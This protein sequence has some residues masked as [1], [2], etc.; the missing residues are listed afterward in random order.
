MRFP[1]RL[2]IF[3]AVLGASNYTFAEAVVSMNTSSWIASHIRDLPVYQWGHLGPSGC[4]LSVKW[5]HCVQ[6]VRLDALRFREF[7]IRNE[8]RFVA[9][10][11]APQSP[12]Y[13]PTSDGVAVLGEV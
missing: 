9:L 13:D 8:I 4:V 3:L 7:E 11:S 5:Y 2:Y 12:T 6:L 1:A 10:V